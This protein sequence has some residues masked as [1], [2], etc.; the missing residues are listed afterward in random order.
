[1]AAFDRELKLLGR[2]KRYDFLGQARELGGA[3]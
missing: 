1:M 2:S 3:D